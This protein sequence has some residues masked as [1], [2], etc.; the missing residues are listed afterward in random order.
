MNIICPN[1]CLQI[2]NLILVINLLLIPTS[3]SCNPKKKDKNKKPDKP[4]TKEEEY[5]S[6]TAERK[7][8]F[9]YYCD[10]ARHHRLC[11]FDCMSHPKFSESCG[12]KQG[13]FRMEQWY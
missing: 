8:N 1:S 2:W 10:I 13:T 5:I 6:E 3:E 12:T 9:K 4:E 11:D 7:I